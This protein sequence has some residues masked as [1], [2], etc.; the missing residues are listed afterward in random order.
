[1]LEFENETYVEYTTEKEKEFYEIVMEYLYLYSDL[2]VDATDISVH[3]RKVPGHGSKPTSHSMVVSVHM[4]CGKT[5]FV[6]YWTIDE[7][8][9]RRVPKIHKRI[10]NILIPLLTEI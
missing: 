3:S 5:A 8:W 10:E 1:M 6:D 9:V 7:D 2:L 4:K